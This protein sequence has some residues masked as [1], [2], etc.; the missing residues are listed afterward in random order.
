MRGIGTWT[1]EMLLIFRLGRPDVF[2]GT[3]YGIRKGYLLTFGKTKVGKP[4]TADM[5][6]KPEADA[7]A[8]GALEAV[9]LGS[10]LVPVAGLRVAAH[11]HPPGKS[12]YHNCMSDLRRR[13]NATSAFTG[14]SISRREKTPGWKPSRPRIRPRPT[15]IG[16]NASPRNAM[17]PTAPR[18]SSMARTRSS[19]S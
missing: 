10:Q 7:A 13:R 18:A 9:A 17:R 3:D 5:L 15:T 14:I 12:S 2:P 11:A 16:T 8:G 6:P 1:A 4:I 19:A